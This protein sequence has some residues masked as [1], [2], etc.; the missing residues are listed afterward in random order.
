MVRTFLKVYMELGSYF[1]FLQEQVKDIIIIMLCSH[2]MPQ[3]MCA[4]A[5][6]HVSCSGLVSWLTAVPGCAGVR[7][8]RITE[9]RFV[10][11]PGL[12]GRA[13]V[14]YHLMANVFVTAAREGRTTRAYVMIVLLL[15]LQKQN[16][17]DGAGMPCH[18]EK[19]CEDITPH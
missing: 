1:L 5:S 16:L 12:T 14:D 6:L 17:V 4:R 11:Q 8:C 18:Q 15:F 2:D 10:M 13:H 9:L 19:T 3:A 7:A